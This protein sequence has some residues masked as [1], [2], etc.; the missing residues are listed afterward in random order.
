TVIYAFCFL[1]A[2]DTL[3]QAFG[4]I[5][6][7]GQA[8]LIGET[9]A[10]IFVLFSMRRHYR[11]IILERAESSGLIV[12]KLGRLL[13]ITLLLVGLLA[14]MAGYARLARLLTP[15]IFVGV[16]LALVMFACLRVSAGLIALG[17]G[18]GPLRS[19]QMVQHHRDL[20]ER[21]IYRLLIW[22]AVINGLF[23]YLNYL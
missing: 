22:A 11:Q 17:L 19:L 15:G 7:I 9:V 6:V 21:K 4:G 12:L 10:A 18:V 13:L 1:F 16:V 3:R 14:A 8:I 5:H 20:L 23:R 2:V